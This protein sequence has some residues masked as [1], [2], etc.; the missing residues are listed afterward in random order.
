MHWGY[1]VLRGAQ[2]G[3]VAG[4]LKRPRIRYGLPFGATA[5][6]AGYVVLPAARLH[7]PLSGCDR[8]TLGK[9]LSGHLVDGPGTATAFQLRSASTNR[10]GDP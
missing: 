7:K 1:G 5:W 10:E 9:D 4:S 2:Y 3:I 6:A 8:Q